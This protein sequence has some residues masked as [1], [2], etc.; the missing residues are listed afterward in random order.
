MA[1]K[2][3]RSMLKNMKIGEVSMVARG[4]NQPAAVSIF[5]IDKQEKSP[6]DVLKAM[7]SEILSGM[8]QGRVFRQ[9]ADDMCV[10]TDA[11]RESFYSVI[12]NPIEYP[13]QKSAI[14]ENLGQFAQVMTAL[15][16]DSE[17]I[18]S[19]EAIVKQAKVKT[20]RGK[21]FPASDFAYVPDKEKPSTWKLRL[22]KV[23]GG[24]PDSGIVGAAVAALGPGFRGQKVQLPST[25]VA[26]V[27]SKVRRAW[28]AADPDRK[29]GD[30]PEVLKK[31][32]EE[33]EMEKTLEFFKAMAELSDA[34][35]E[36]YQGLE[37]SA[38]DEIT[39]EDM[40]MDQIVAA[41]RKLVKP[42]KKKPFVAKSNDE[43]FKMGDLV[44]KKSEVGDA[45]FIVMKA[46]QVEIDLAKSET[47]EAKDKLADIALAKEAGELFPN[48]PGT[49]E[50]KGQILKSIRQMPEAQQESQI[51]MM[52]AGDAA[53]AAQM[54]EK[55]HGNRQDGDETPTE[56]LNKMA[57]EKAATDGITFAKA[58]TAVMDT[59]EG[60]ALYEKTLN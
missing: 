12:H 18:K 56:T 59:P 31:S 2:K 8:E 35:K 46:Q 54:I 20:E 45:A 17:I 42:A 26:G 9:L 57:T 52:K 1:P 38:Q 33:I 53:V 37:K 13:D 23:P 36:F 48:L 28:L 39:K 44:V 15:V 11:F 22:T 24:K 3:K 6:E 27:K 34:E 32:Q 21:K 10:F 58:Y 4:A 47:A 60:A 5:K 7:F 41:L 51:K 16:D 14:K 43:T 49:N 25:A 19:F 30:L 29:E 55:G 40:S 50:E